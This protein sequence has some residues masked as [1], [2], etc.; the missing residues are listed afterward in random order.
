MYVEV[1]GTLVRPAS[2]ISVSSHRAL[3]TGPLQ[4]SPVVIVLFLRVE[5]FM[6]LH[7]VSALQLLFVRH[8]MLGQL[9]Y[10]A[11]NAGTL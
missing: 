10:R 9:P 2:E 1:T 4:L 11:S 5:V 7:N 8:S 3:E 6:E